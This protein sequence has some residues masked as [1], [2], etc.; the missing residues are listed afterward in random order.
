[1][2]KYPNYFES[3]IEKVHQLEVCRMYCD[4]H[5]ASTKAALQK[6]DF[7]TS[8]GIYYWHFVEEIPRL[9]IVKASIISWHS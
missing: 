9:V 5:P 1:M 3:T 6:L 7:R 4:R 8:C 2:N